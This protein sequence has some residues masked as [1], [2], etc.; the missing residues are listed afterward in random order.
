MKQTVKEKSDE[1]NEAVKQHRDEKV[2]LFRNLS[3][4]RF[5]SF[6]ISRFELIFTTVCAITGLD[7][8]LTVAN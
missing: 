3:N 1:L 4:I 2:G 8:R 5:S 7:S 6:F